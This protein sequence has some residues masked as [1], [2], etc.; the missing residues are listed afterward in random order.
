LK[1][2]TLHSTQSVFL[3]LFL[4][5]AATKVYSQE[6]KAEQFNFTELARKEATQSFQKQG[7]HE[8]DGGWRYLKGNQP[9]PRG[10]KLLKQNPAL[11]PTS[12]R[13]IESASPPPLQSFL[14]HI[15]PINFIPP[16]CHG[17]VGLNNVVTATNEFIIV[18]AKN[19]GAVLS[20]VTFSNFFNTPNMSDP[21]MQFDPYLNRYWVSGISTTTTN[22]VFIAVSQTSDPAGNWYRYSFTP[23]STDGA[24]LLDHPYL[25]FD[26]RLLVVT[27]RK[28]PG[29]TNFSGTIL[30]IFNKDSLAAGVPISFG[31]N[32]QTIEKG[33]ADGDVPSPV[34]A[35]DLT[36]PASTFYILQDWNGSSSAIRLSTITGN[37]PNLSWNT[38]AAVFPSG[39]TP[40]SDAQLGNLAPQLGESRLI[41][42]N[43]SRISSAQMVNGKIWCAHHI[44]LPATNFNHTAVQWW[45]LTTAGAVLQRGRID[46][47]TGQISRYYPTIAVN[48]A[49]NVVIGY[50]ISSPT[51]RINAAYSTRT[52]SS[53]LNTTDDEYIFKGGI[54]TYWKDY[55]S[56]RARWG[57]Y[58]H[59]SVDPV[60]GDLWTIQQYADQ[61]LSAADND[62]RY[63]VWWAEISFAS[64]NNDAS[65][66]NIVQPNGASPYCSTPINPTVTVRNVG[67]DT[68]KSVKVGL[69]L[70]GVN[71]GVTSLTGLSISLY[72]SID[73]SIPIPLNPAPGNHIL[74]AYTFEPNGLPD[75]RTSNDTSSVAF[76]V[77]QTMTLPDFEGFES[78]IFPPAGGWSLYNPDGGLS[79]QRTTT[80]SKTGIA[81]M[82]LNAFNY[83]TTKSVDILKSPKILLANID[84]INVN[85]DLAYARYSS[86]SED[87]L[88]IVYSIDCGATWLPTSYNKGG[89]SLATNGGVFVTTDFS[90]VI[91]E[92][93]HESVGISTCGINASSILI[94]VKSINDFGNNIYVDNLALT[95]VDTK[96][97]NAAVLAIN[98]PVGTLCTPDFTPEVIIANYGTDTLKTLTINYQVDN[99]AINTFNFVGSLAKCNSQVVTLNPVTSAPGNHILTVFSTLPNGNADQATI[100]DTTTKSVAIAPLLDAPVTE[101]F[102]STTFPPTNWSVLNPDGLLTWERTT[103]AA[104]T[105]TA[106][107]VIRNFDY[108]L[109]NTVDD[110]ISPVIKYSAAVDSF[111]V[112]FDYA[113]AQGV[114]Y[115]G[116]TAL[117]L[118]TLELQLTQDCGSTFTSIWKK[119]GGDLQTIGD[120]NLPVTTAFIPNSSQWKNVNIYLNPFIGISNFQLYFVA[121]SNKQNNLYIDNINIYPKI[122]PKRLKDQGYLL[123]PNPFRNTFT[124]RNYQVPTTLQTVSI[125]NFVGQLVWRKNYNGS[126]YTEMPIDLSNQ[127]A[128]IYVVKLTYTDKTVETRIVKQ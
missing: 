105:G 106:S 110:F 4:T 78:P 44:G 16:D 57:D 17:T 75:Q 108:P 121:K 11:I 95:K 26:N 116:S 72:N 23:T 87:S 83:T 1:K 84:S 8:L 22:K 56:G 111:F 77:L 80:A 48:P 125:Y 123:Y 52:Q 103:A 92:W 35:L 9:I 115:P 15:D 91:S 50:T 119:W 100:N 25:G 12:P 33:V 88:Q 96:Q 93:R 124:L 36:A 62:S 30:F 31:S 47:S 3:F 63:G 118:D 122:L 7:E 89:A 81:S 101:G 6:I 14:G 65:L 67:S 109:A 69:I 38:S 104:K 71:L 112:S 64:F 58:S 82:E 45:E 99:G 113:Y 66:A 29:G 42:V 19:G 76:S 70:D 2:F 20:Q 53:P 24:L 55:G 34:T 94:G 90:P 5:I 79:W 120:P 37:L 40:W 10:A 73:V 46:D 39:G 13:T 59:S 54:S 43:D 107:M 127:A 61:R 74:Q 28:F 97:S 126:G 68:I 85:F 32:S 102:E 27:G 128:G 21:Y 86:S 117:P 98:K 51:T 41:A 49:E 60:T 18:H 114:Q